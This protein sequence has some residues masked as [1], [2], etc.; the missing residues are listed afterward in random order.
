VSVGNTKHEDRAGVLITAKGPSRWAEGQDPNRVI[1]SGRS[2]A[3]RTIRPAPIVS[4]TMAKKSG[5]DSPGGRKRFEK[6]PHL[7][8]TGRLNR[9]PMSSPLR[10]DM[11]RR[12]RGK[13]LG[14]R[15]IKGGHP[16]AEKGSGRVVGI[17]P[18]ADNQGAM[19]DERGG[20]KDNDYGQLQAKRRH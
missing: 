7:L 17:I 2:T 13:G 4:N 3:Q 8:G 10:E 20:I 11:I 18:V 1:L 14:C 19:M 12:A 9:T 6:K 5:G 15:K 16:G